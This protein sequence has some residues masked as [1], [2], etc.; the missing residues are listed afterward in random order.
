MDLDAYSA[1]HGAE[2][3]RLARLGETRHLDGATAD[4]LIEHYQAGATHLSVIRTTV[5]E[6]AQGDRLSLALSRARLRFT[7]T[8]AE[9]MRQLTVFFTHQLPA[10]FYRVRWTT[11]AVAAATAVVFLVFFSWYGSDP[12]LIATLG[13]PAQLENYATQ[14]FVGYYDANSEA[15]FTGQVWTNNAWLA[16]QCIMFGVLGI[17]TPV[18]L[19]QTG[20]SLGIS[21]AI[22][23]EYGELDH[24]F[25]Y[26]SPHGQLELYSVFVAG[27]A[28]LMIFWSWIAPGARTRRQALAEDG[29]AFFTLVIGLTLSLLI[30]GI[31][32]GFVTRQDWPWPIKI[33]I[34][35]VALAVVLV[36]QWVLGRRA[37]RA[38]QTGDLGEFDAGA[39]QIVSA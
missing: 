8:P 39:R 1:A 9:P 15:G 3:D 33:G 11:L 6:S 30:S 20:S 17:W 25:L 27:A 16:A 21:A 2:W 26:I 32:E 31:I 4:E 38:G 28:G 22:M 29:R 12:R 34:G 7:G 13:T 37:F 14:Q 23:A 36:Y 5:G 19:L 18:V 35:T 10:A 24:F